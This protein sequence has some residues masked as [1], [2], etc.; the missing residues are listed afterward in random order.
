VGARLR[1]HATPRG[2]ASESREKRV[3][4]RRVRLPRGKQIRIPAIMA[5]EIGSLVGLVLLGHPILGASLGLGLWY[6]K[7]KYG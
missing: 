1:K 5:I 7:R 3:E 4:Q 6:V 2:P